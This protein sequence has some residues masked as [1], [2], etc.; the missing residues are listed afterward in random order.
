[1]LKLFAS[2]F[3]HV[4]VSARLRRGRIS[5]EPAPS[6]VEGTLTALA[7]AVQSHAECIEQAPDRANALKA[8]L[9]VRCPILVHPATGANAL[10]PGPLPGC[11]QPGSAGC[12]SC[13]PTSAGGA[14]ARQLAQPAAGHAGGSGHH[15][16]PAACTRG[17]IAGGAC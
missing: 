14:C 15:R 10:N 13:T 2:L 12:R 7:R 17:S 9:A 1:M 3:K 8:A 6:Q 4:C 11:A 5:L 16:Q